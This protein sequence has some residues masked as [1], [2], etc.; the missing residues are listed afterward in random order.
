MS[1]PDEL[2][3]LIVD[4]LARAGIEATINTITPCVYG[5]NNRIYRVETTAGDFAAKQYFRHEGDNR[6]RLAA[7]YAFLSY[8]STAAPRATPRAYACNQE[9]GMALY[10][11]VEGRPFRV[12]EID[13]V[14]VDA[15]TR[16]FRALNEPLLRANAQLPIASE[17]SFSI[18]DHLTLINGRLKR[19]R[20]ITPRLDIDAE[21]FDF[22]RQLDEFWHQLSKIIHTNASGSNLNIDKPLLPEQRCISPSDFGFHNALRDVSGSIR[23][24]DF[25]YAGWDDPAKMVGDFFAQ[26]AVPVPADYYDHFV[27][28]SLDVF[29]NPE[30][31]IQ[32]AALLRP[33]YQIKWCC[34]ALNV[35]I[36]VHFARR[37]F[38]NPELDE[39]LLKQ[40][41]LTKAKQILQSTS[42]NT[43]GLH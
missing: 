32:R 31:H 23:F 3:T 43:H 6:D 28:H 16:F 10:E 12:D 35:F 25:E 41:Q 8:A 19:L 34:I 29:Q 37:K 15:A 5:G 14:Q 42:K 26:L 39:T 40:T 2:Y 13:T 33:V 9:T 30:F 20:E 1:L 7:E 4:L 22:F 27:T 11:F 18:A 17:A 21:A 38:A 24:L 36:P